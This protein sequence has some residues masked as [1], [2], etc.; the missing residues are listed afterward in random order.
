[1]KIHI[2]STCWNESAMIP[3]Y[4]RHY[5]AFA[6]KIIIYD[7]ASTDGTREKIAANPKAEVKNWPYKSGMDDNIFMKFWQEVYRSQRG[8]C[9]W[10]ILPDIDEFIWA[11]EGV[12]NVLDKAEKEGFDAV[13]TEGFNMTG[14]GTLTQDGVPHDVGQQLVDTLTHGVAAP[15]Y[16]K[17]IVFKPTANINWNRGRHAL[18]NCSPKITPTPRLKLLHYRYMGFEYSKARNAR[19]YERVGPDKGCAWSCAP[20]YKGE[21]SAEWSIIAKEKSFKVS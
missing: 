15:V 11:K 19:N 13:A 18:E 7:D 2:V 9:D 20:T 14:D 3:F 4:L 17:P 6:D 12:R 8:Q 21:H 16:A 5:S 1:M 10:I